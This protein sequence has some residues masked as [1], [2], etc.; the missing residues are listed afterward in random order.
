MTKPAAKTATTLRRG[1]EAE[2]KLLNANYET[3]LSFSPKVYSTLDD[4]IDARVKTVSMLPGAQTMARSSAE[5]LVRRGTTAARVS[6]A[7]T[8][9]LSSSDTDTALNTAVDDPG[10]P[11]VRFTH[12]TALYSPSLYYSTE[13]HVSYLRLGLG[14]GINLRVC[15]LTRL[16]A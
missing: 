1:I 7:D 9:S 6:V 16:S 13:E 12:D 2:H 11:A 10:D 14:L 4:A 8:T 3:K 15:L 5:I